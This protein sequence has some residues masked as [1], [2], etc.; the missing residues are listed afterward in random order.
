[1]IFTITDVTTST[2]LGTVSVSTSCVGTFATT[3]H[4]TQAVS[5]NDFYTV[6]SGTDAT[7]AN[8]VIDFRA[9]RN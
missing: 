9:V 3:G 6:V 4:A 7:A 1:V 2:T 5:A 8:I